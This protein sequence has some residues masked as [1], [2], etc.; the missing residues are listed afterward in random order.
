MTMKRWISSLLA[1]ALCLSLLIAPAGAYVRVDPD[2]EVS[3]SLTYTHNEKGVEGLSI[4]IYKVYDMSDAVA[5][6]AEPDFVAAYGPQTVENDEGET[7]T[8]TGEFT[9]DLDKWSS[10]DETTGKSQ[11]D[12]TGMAT[13][14]GGLLQ[15]DIANNAVK[16]QPLLTRETDADGKVT[17]ASVAA[18]EGVEPVTMDAGLYLVLGQT[19][20]D[21]RSTYTPQSFLVSLP[22]LVADTDSWEYD[23]AYYDVEAH[24]KLGYH[25]DNP[26]GGSTSVTVVKVWEDDGADV[27]RPASIRV[28]LL[29]NGQAYDTV[30]LNEANGWKYTWNRLSDSAQ[31]TVVEASV[32]EGYSVSISQNNNE[33]VITNTADTDLDD[34]DPPLGPDPDEGAPGDLP[35]V[36]LGDDDVP[37]G[38]LPDTGILWWPVQLLT[39]AGIVLFS[40]GW[41]DLRRNKKR[42]NEE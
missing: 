31:W 6:T 40:I 14:L 7:V 4:S 35:D 20:V 39:A 18:S 13:T 24:G 12:W 5:F 38:N 33:F 41:L 15:R 22:H 10:V 30:T 25:Y 26:T 9:F 11:V 29:R 28:Q 23:Y 21:G 17:F 3:L 1:A 32:P 36:D 2:K 37:L 27:E 34:D 42:G 19:M 8:T 16:V